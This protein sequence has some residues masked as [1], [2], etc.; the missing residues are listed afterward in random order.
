MSEGRLR[1]RGLYGHYMN[2]STDSAGARSL[3]VVFGMVDG[4]GQSFALT[5]AAWDGRES[6]A[7]I[8]IR[9]IRLRRRR[10]WGRRRYGMAHHR[11]SLT[12]LSFY[13][14]RWL[15]ADSAARLFTFATK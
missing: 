7:W 5:R 1:K 4:Q 12:C 6:R 10:R 2:G 15:L 14:A 11:R 8:R 9:G 13:C 3:A